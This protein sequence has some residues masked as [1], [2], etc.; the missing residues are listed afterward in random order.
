MEDNKVEVKEVADDAIDA[1][2]M[3]SKAFTESVQE[4]I[5]GENDAFIRC[6]STVSETKLGSA[7]ASP[8]SKGPVKENIATPSQFKSGD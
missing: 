8:A 4:E 7:V 3:K 2:M 5:Q 6:S 1:K